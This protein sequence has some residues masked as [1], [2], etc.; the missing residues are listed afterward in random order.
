VLVL[1]SR[2]NGK[3]HVPAVLAPYWSLMDGIPMIL[4]TSTKLDYAKESWL[5]AVRMMERVARRPGDPLWGAIP[6]TRRDWV[7]QANGECGWTLGDPAYPCQY[8]IAPANEEGG[9]SLTIDRL[10]MDELRQH[11]DR[12]AW[13]AAVPATEAVPTAQAWALSNAGDDRSVVLNAERSAALRTIKT[14]EGDPRVGLFEWSAPENADPTDPEALAMAN[15]QF[16]RRMDPDRMLGKAR[17]AVVE[18]GETLAGFKTESMC[19]RVITQNPAIDPGSWARCL[20]PGSLADLRARVAVCVDVAPDGGHV[21]LYAAAVLDD[22]RVR[23]DP[24]ES[25]AGRGCVDAAERAL[26]GQLARVRPVSLGWFPA[27]PG[28]ALAARLKDR[29]VRGWPPPGVLVEEI[30]AEVHAVCM[31]FEQQVIARQ[32]A[33]SGDP[34]LDAHVAIAEKLHSG[35]VWRFDRDGG[36]VDAVYA[37]AG[38]VHLAKTMPAPLGKPRVIRS[39]RT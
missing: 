25:W 22:G 26:P 39:T 21:T 8:K 31:A 14:G 18:G 9:R 15:P 7:R 24:V 38:A 3:T 34:L 20:D 12:S 6:D 5:K 10:V 33:H 16:G 23:V 2:Q 17:T 32:I 1:V 4:G 19:I 36:H 35:D 30:R 11:H 13:N 37:A 29:K 28:A 27:G